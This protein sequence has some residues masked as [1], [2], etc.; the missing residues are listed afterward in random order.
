MTK[1]LRPLYFIAGLLLVAIG[2]VG[3]FVPLLPTTGPL[4]LAAWCFA[5]SSKRAEA[6][7]LANPQF[8]P[9]I[10]A[11]RQN[12][13]IARRHKLMALGGMSVGLVVFWLGSQPAWWLLG[14]VALALVAC[15]VFVWTRP[16]PV[17]AES[18]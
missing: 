17:R 1:I 12:G 8:G 9:A 3:I 2:I 11:W 15:A 13:A 7:L 6:W 5:R 4:I 10:I 16:E 18:N 14:L